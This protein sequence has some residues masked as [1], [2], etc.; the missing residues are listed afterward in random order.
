MDKSIVINANESITQTTGKTT[1]QWL[2]RIIV[3]YLLFGEKA[4]GM[5]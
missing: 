5:I 4:Q 2:L 1:E 3:L